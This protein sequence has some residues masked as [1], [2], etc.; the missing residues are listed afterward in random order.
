WA[1]SDASGALPNTSATASVLLALI[2]S[3]EH[4]TNAQRDRI[5]RSTGRGIVWLLELQN[6]DGGWATFY[7]DDALLRRDESGTD[8]TAQ[9]LGALA[10]RRR[11]WRKDTSSEAKRRWSYIDER[12]V[13]AI[14]NGW[15]YLASHQQEDG[16]FIPMWFGNE[17]QAHETNPVYGTTQVLLASAELDR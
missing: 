8:I 4:A 15:K 2:R 6:E 12:A 9:A 10:A 13:R 7:R 16:S 14:E 17:H 11:D 1:S 5:E 3:R